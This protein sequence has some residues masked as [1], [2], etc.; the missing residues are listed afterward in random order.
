MP[1]DTNNNPREKKPEPRPLGREIILIL[2]MLILANL[3]FFPREPR[4]EEVPYSQFIDQVESGQVESAE[5]GTERIRYILK[6]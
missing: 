6:A 5:V 4:F 3:F 1:I 2:W